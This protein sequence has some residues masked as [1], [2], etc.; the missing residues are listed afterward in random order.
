MLEYTSHAVIKNGHIRDILL[1]II[2]CKCQEKRMR[3]RLAQC[4]RHRMNEF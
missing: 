2:H 1:L 4:T 3:R